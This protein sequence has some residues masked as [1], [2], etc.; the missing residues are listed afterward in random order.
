[1]TFKIIEL[2]REN[3]LNK[4][5]KVYKRNKSETKILFTSLWDDWCNILLDK[6]RLKY[7]KNE[8]GKKLYVVNSFNMPHSFV[9]FNTL[10]APSLVTLKEDKTKVVDYLP[11]I[12]RDLGV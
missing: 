9:I 3:D 11:L 1:M 6:L 7:G 8:K 10:K 5:L 4:I 2:N 12:Y